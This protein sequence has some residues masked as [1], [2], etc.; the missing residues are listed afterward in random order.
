MAWCSTNRL[1]DWAAGFADVG[2]GVG[3]CGRGGAAKV[4]SVARKNRAK[5]ALSECRLEMTF[6]VH[7]KGVRSIS[8]R[9]SVDA[10]R[11]AVIMAV[12]PLPDPSPSGT[13]KGSRLPSG[14]GG[15]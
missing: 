9:R 14:H 4:V 15:D 7:V 8:N 12:T 11:K 5:I 2:A 1:I 6:F 10:I 3:A 13:Q